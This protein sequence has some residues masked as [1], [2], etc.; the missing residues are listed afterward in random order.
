[1][2]GAGNDFVVID[3]RSRQVRNGSRAARILCDRR[4]GIGADGLLLLEKSRRAEY[5]MMYFNA[6][7][8]YGGMCGNGGRCMARFAVMNGLAPR[9]HRFEALQHI[10]LAS[11]KNSEVEL[12]MI[13]PVG[14][15]LEK[16]IR[17]QGKSVSVSHVDTGSPHVVVVCSAL[18]ARKRLKSVDVV[19][20]G[21][22]IRD[23]AAFKPGGTNVNFIERM[24]GNLIAIRT[25]ERGVEA[26]TMACGTGS[27]AAAIVASRLWE[28]RSPIDVIPESKKTLRVEF[29]DNGTNITNVRLIGPAVVSFYGIFAL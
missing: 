8:S 24:R 27:I 19:T 28:L 6:D 10:Y 9:K 12:S 7:G 17:L 4:W 13:D 16:K 26:E 14:L 5:R 15:R 21:R 22:E 25:Y 2:S 11:V 20:L 29:V 3:N 23:H 18:G 1:M